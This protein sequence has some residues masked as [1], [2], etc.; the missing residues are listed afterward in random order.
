MTGGKLI[1]MYANNTVMQAKLQGK[2]LRLLPQYEFE[3][4]GRRMISLTQAYTDVNGFKMRISKNCAEL[5]AASVDNAKDPVLADLMQNTDT[6]NILGAMVR[7]GMTIE[8]AGA[9]FSHPEIRNNPTGRGFHKMIKDTPNLLTVNVAINEMQGW[10]NR[11]T[12]NTKDLID[13]IAYIN[14]AGGI[15]NFLEGWGLLHDT[16]REMVERT[17]SVTGNAV[18]KGTEDYMKEGLARVQERKPEVIEY[19][20]NYIEAMDLYEDIARIGE[21]VGNLTNVSRADSPNGAI[22][23]TFAKAIKQQA[24]VRKLLQAASKTRE[25]HEKSQR[26]GKAITDPVSSILGM[27]NV[28]P[29]NNYLTLGYTKERMRD[30][31]LKSDM[32]MLQ[33]FYS[34]GI[35]LGI[36]NISQYFAP[37][38]AA[39]K[40]AIDVFIQNTPY[41]SVKDKVLEDF[42]FGM[43]T[44]ML[45][46]TKFFGDEE[47]GLTYEQKRDYYLK[48]F[49]A[50][51][52]AMKLADPTLK[53]NKA[54]RA[55][56]FNKKKGALVMEKS[57]GKRQTV[58]EMLMGQFEQLIYQNPQ[59]AK[60]LLMYSFYKDGLNFGP[61]SYGNYFSPTFLSQFPEVVHAL[62]TMDAGTMASAGISDT[63]GEV[64]SYYTQFLLQNYE[65]MGLLSLVDKKEGGMSEVMEMM[66]QKSAPR[67]D[68]TLASHRVEDKYTGLDAPYIVY[69]GSLYK[70]KTVKGLVDGKMKT[71][72]TLMAPFQLSSPVYNA[73]YAGKEAA[74]F[75]KIYAEEAAEFAKSKEEWSMEDWFDAAMEDR[76][77]QAPMFDDEF[78]EDSAIDPKQATPE[79]KDTVE[80]STEPRVV[81]KVEQKYSPEEGL[82]ENNEEKC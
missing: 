6:A 60:D 63:R 17:R 21:D 44:Y 66:N 11:G 74:L 19:L 55:L 33:A 27:E 5:A 73:K 57:T 12:V 40:H 41:K 23:H 30:M 81:P 67:T 32:P 36:Q 28:L 65:R 3:I 2:D 80:L 8:E 20:R 49:P 54:I 10:R 18:I 4:N 64:S 15:E 51:F 69:N 78:A 46:K 70:L 42:L 25:A 45:G 24:N 72:Y 58:R 47:G 34:L 62:R 52:E 39:G 31:L 35:D 37:Y 71:A 22:Q 76:D 48:E 75:S 77:N 13:A 9:F 7:L 59:M 82:R 29:L 79:I 26:E 53:Q 43:T 14:D 61:G 1:G 38:Q 16:H 68:I 50:I 56:T